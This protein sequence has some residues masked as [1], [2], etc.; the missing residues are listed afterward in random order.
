[1]CCNAAVVNRI[2]ILALIL[3]SAPVFAQS[4]APWDSLSSYAKEQGVTVKG[5]L[6]TFTRL[7]QPYAPLDIQVVG[8]SI[9]EARLIKGRFFGMAAASSGI[10]L[11]KTIAM[12][13]AF[14]CQTCGP[15]RVE[16]LRKDLPEIR[17]LVQRFNAMPNE[18]LILAQWGIPGDFRINSIFHQGAL[19]Q[20]YSSNQNVFPGAVVKRFDDASAALKLF[21]IQQS[22]FEAML[23]QMEMAHIVALLRTPDGVRA[24]RTGV[25]RS[26]AGLLFVANKGEIPKPREENNGIRINGFIKEADDVF[27]FES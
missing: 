23:K 14:H 9:D 7:T 2:L 13:D 19:T 16:D 25:T 17:L 18:V 22:D 6:T 21:G 20:E 15:A 12:T 8:A 26:I 11:D 1:L 3:L 5:D 10:G 4:S 27:Y 24:I